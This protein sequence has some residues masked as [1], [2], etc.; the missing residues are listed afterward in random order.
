ML[1]VACTATASKFVFKCL[2]VK[3]SNVVRQRSSQ[4]IKFERL[5][6]GFIN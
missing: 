5:N 6:K 4:N 3:L 2:P 1:F